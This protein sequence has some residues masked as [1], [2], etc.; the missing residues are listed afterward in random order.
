MPIAFTICSNN[1]LA[2]AK[3]AADT[4]MAIHPHFE[5]YIFL[6]DEFNKEIDYNSFLPAKIVE[7]KDVVLSINELAKKYNIIELNTAVKPSIFIHLFEKYK[8]DY[9]IYLDP[10]VMVYDKF[11]EIEKLLVEEKYNIIITP[12]FC[13][14]I[15]DGKIPSDI[16]FSTYG[17]YNLGFIAIKNSAESTRFLSWWH[18]RLM[19]YCYIDV[20]NGMFT[21]QLWVNYAPIY[22]NG[23][24]ILKDLNYNVANWNLYEREIDETGDGYYIKGSGKMKFFHFSHYKFNDPYIISARQ[25]RHTI[26]DVKNMKEIIDEYQSRLIKNNYEAYNKIPCHYQIIYEASQPVLPKPPGALQMLVIKAKNKTIRVAK[27][28]FQAKDKQSK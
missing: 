28:A 13:S 2:K 17:L 1:Y 8:S 15:D 24:Y 22:F 14:P 10:D 23:V 7:I 3:V 21:D 5:F 16:H 12:H 27:N 6:V 19:K 4:F 26:D 20:A 25:N 11:I 18:E 9:I